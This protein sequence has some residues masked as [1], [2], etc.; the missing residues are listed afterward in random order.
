M[1]VW[2]VFFT[3]SWITFKSKFGPIIGDLQATR[4]RLNE[5]KLTSAMTEIQSLRGEVKDSTQVVLQQLEKN[6]EET[7]SSRKAQAE[8][9]RQYR[10]QCVLTKLGAPSVTEDQEVAVGERETS[11]S[12]NWLQKLPVFKAW[13]EPKD[14]CAPPTLFLNGIPGAGKDHEGTL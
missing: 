6:G 12:G 10:L 8:E 4:E 5:E 1:I 9:Q 3:T 2:R 14:F 11:D 7:Q 13:L